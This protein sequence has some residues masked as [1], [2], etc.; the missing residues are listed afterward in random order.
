MKKLWTCIAQYFEGT[1]SPRSAIA[2]AAMI[3][4]SLRG[5]PTPTDPGHHV[6]PTSIQ[7]PLDP[8][9]DERNEDSRTER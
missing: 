5:G 4:E 6:P 8:S 9:S 3:L 2:G 7:E 1:A